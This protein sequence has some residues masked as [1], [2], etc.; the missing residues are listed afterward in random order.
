MMRNEAGQ[1]AD[2]CKHAHFVDLLDHCVQNFALKWPKD[3]SFVLDR[4]HHKSLARLDDTRSDLVYRRHRYHESVLSRAGALHF[5]VEFL[6]HGLQQLRAKV[7]WMKQNLLL[8]RY[9]RR[10][11]LA[12]IFALFGE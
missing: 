6:L 5:G 3:D 4:I 8:Q 2:L 11:G 7:T 10:K 1:R 9:L 12:F